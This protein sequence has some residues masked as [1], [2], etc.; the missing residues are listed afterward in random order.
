MRSLL[1]LLD[2]RSLL[3]LLGWRGLWGL[4]GLLG[5]RSLWSLLGLLGWRS[6][7]GLRDWLGLRSLRSLRS[8]LGLLGW[9]S[10]RGLL[11]VRRFVGLGRLGNLCDLRGLRN[12][13]AKEKHGSREP[14]HDESKSYQ[15][16]DGALHRGFPTPGSLIEPCFSISSAHGIIGRTTGA[17][18]PNPRAGEDRTHHFDFLNVSGTVLELPSDGE[19]RGGPCASW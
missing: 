14:A 1:D 8:L 2:L 17:A 11:D 3:G 13:L 6:L 12:T 18:N 16:H 10:L 4:W 19:R 5:L 9:L 7:R 15:C